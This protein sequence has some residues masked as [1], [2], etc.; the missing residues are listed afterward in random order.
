VNA[1]TGWSLG[2]TWI[3]SLPL[4]FSRFSFLHG[5]GEGYP[6]GAVR[7]VP[8]SHD[9]CWDPPFSWLSGRIGYDETRP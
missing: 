5:P 4:G 6:A 3:I 2:G 9:P 8:S 1:R 7:L